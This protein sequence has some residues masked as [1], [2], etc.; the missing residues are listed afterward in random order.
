MFALYSVL[1]R[2]ALVLLAPRAAWDVVRGGRWGV[3][4]RERL[5]AV[6]ARLEDQR[7]ALWIHAVS[8]GEV[9]AAR[10]LI[11][12]LRT[13]FPGVPV[14]VST[15][16]AT[17]QAIA[18]ARSGADAM[19]FM[20]I[21]LPAALDP[22]LDAL[23]PR[24]LLL[25]ETEIWPNLLRACAQRAVPVG[26]VNARL[27]ERS[28]RRYGWLRRWWPAPLQ[29]LGLVC[30]RTDAEAAR[31]RALDLD[32]AVIWA[33]GNLKAD[34]EALQP[35]AREREHL[36]ETL[37][38]ADGELLLVAG[39]TTAGEEEHVLAAFASLRETYPALRLLLA[40]RHPQ[41]F[42]Q[43]EALIAR[44]GYRCSRRS[45]DGDHGAADVLLLDTIG[46]LP[47]AY[48]LG[49]VSFVGG[50]LVPAGGHNLLEPAVQSQPVLF[51]PHTDNFR[52]LAAALESAGGGV[53]VIDAV[54]L[55]EVAGRLLANEQERRQ[56]GERARAT[57]LQD[58]GAGARTA[59]VVREWL[60]AGGS[61]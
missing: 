49:T 7:G 47:A 20:P 56:L 22:Y 6:P 15:T 4:L 54:H 9:H 32:P 60:T 8:V 12:H 11:P 33:T 50:S 53:R 28:F 21:D 48:G 17:G 25:V 51:G 38:L 41:R 18:R 39:C 5:G 61:R 14:V 10:G 40:P 1:Y 58:G 23:R 57:A 37:S 24:A 27:S 19:F 55:A 29:M 13:E 26:M 52:D 2:T 42:D 45:R 31:F 43:V 44:S 46:E 59:R 16:T 30:A 3:A 36:R 34:P 35:S